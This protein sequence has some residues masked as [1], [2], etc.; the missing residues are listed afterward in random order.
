[1][2]YD[3]PWYL[4]FF[5]WVLGLGFFFLHLL[6]MHASKL[7]LIHVVKMITSYHILLLHPVQVIAPC[8][9]K[10]TTD[11]TNFPFHDSTRRKGL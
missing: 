7:W 3:V 2:K 1:M 5:S 8:I 11:Q 4:V 6:C 10:C 9:W